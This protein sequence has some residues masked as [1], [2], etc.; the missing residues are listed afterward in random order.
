MLTPEA[1]KAAADPARFPEQ[2][3]EGLEPWRVLKVYGRVFAQAQGPAAVFDVGQF[4]AVLG[5]SYAEL[6]ADGR[7]R[8]R[9]QDF[10]MIQPR[11]SA[12]RSFPR[13]ES[14]VP[15]TDRETSVFAGIDTSIEGAAKLAGTKGDALLPSL[16]IIS[17]AARRAASEF[18]A[19]APS[20]IAP[21]LAA[22]LRE[23]RKLKAAIGDLDAISRA[24]LKCILDRKEFEFSD[25][26]IKAHGIVVDALAN[27]EIVTPGES[28]D[29]TVN[30]YLNL[31]K[32]GENGGAK[33]QIKLV[34]PASW[35][36]EQ[37]P[38]DTEQ[39]AGPQQG[40]RQRE[41]PDE[42]SRLR[43]TVPADE[44]VTEP[45]WLRRERTRDQ[46]DWDQTMPRTLPFAPPR[47]TA[48]VDLALAGETVTLKQTVEY[49]F[50]D[51]TFGEIRRDLKVAPALT[52]S[53]QPNLLIVPSGSQDRT[54]NVAVEVTHHARTS[55]TGE[56]K[57]LMPTGFKVENDSRPLEFTRPGEKTLRQ[58]RITVPPG[59]SG[60]FD[61][62]AMAE[63]AGRKFTRGF[64][65]IS[66]PHIEKHLVYH[67]A[68]SKIELF[69]VKVAPGLRVGYVMGSG[70]DGPEAL[71]QLGVDVKLID[72]SELL[73]GQLSKY[74]TIVLGIRVYEVRDDVIA[75]NRR[76]LDYVNDGGTLIVQYNKTE[77]VRGNFAPY[78]V[79]MDGNNRVTDEK[80][81]VEMLVPDHPL[82]R[83]PN[84]ITE[85]DWKGWV[86]ERGLYFLNEWDSRYTSLLGSV[87][88]AGRKQ[89]G[90]QLITK[91]GKG[92]YVFTG[93]AWFRQLPAG[94]P[95]A[96]RMFANL[97]SLSKT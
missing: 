35:K 32:G 43:V 96:Y 40:M 51:K 86:Q 78:P 73:S 9:S 94:V 88:E 66:Y 7:S 18:R 69:D 60:S 23:V 61:L 95:G 25:S 55:T 20:M 33:S 93:Y 63:S 68:K 77:F 14:S 80:A 26:L 46:F 38:S 91:V 45:Y 97:V 44:P 30:V 71:K 62:R 50:S 85:D 53:L 13:I 84:K 56:V 21:H 1:I 72:E 34:A 22:G 19:D 64:T 36:I 24:N 31:A 75:N 83:F 52:L 82:F 92:N 5:R 42:L 3:K 70:D 6:A 87:D 28:L 11:G 59:V 8:H 17:E 65:A 76:L 2:L 39:G 27:T 48:Q 47:L 49:R 89:L 90:G 37:L 57:L 58:F 15:V 74:D 54:R 79:K 12:V 81:P 29:V 4:D 41:R 10:G 16:K 67:E